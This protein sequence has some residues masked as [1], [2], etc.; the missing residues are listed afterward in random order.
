M[1]ALP[2]NSTESQT[3]ADAPTVLDTGTLATL[4]FGVLATL[5]SI[6]TIVLA[7]LQLNK[8][9]ERHSGTGEVIVLGSRFVYIILRTSVRL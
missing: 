1:P 6:L 3:A 9:P 7:F 5:A 8:M 2:I 4:I